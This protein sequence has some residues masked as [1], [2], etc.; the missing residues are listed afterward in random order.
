[1]I[2]KRHLYWIIVILFF[3]NCARQT[4]P[5]GGPKD[6]IPPKLIGA[7]PQHRALNF[8]GKTVELTFSEFVALNNPKEQL[9]ITP[10]PGKEYELA[11]KKTKIT[12]ELEKPLLDSTTYTFNFRDAVQDITE[13]NS[14]RNLLIAISTGSYL[15]SL[16]IE[17]KV[18]DLLKGTEL[19]DITVAIN[20]QNDTFNIFKHPATYFTKTN[21]KGTFKL[22]YLR[23]D[24]YSIYAID[25]RNRN[26][27]ADSR[28]E[29]YGFIS[30]PII[31]K[32]DT[33]KIQIA[34]I[35]L[36]ARPLKLTSARP[37][38]TY[39]NIKASKN[40]QGFTLKATDTTKLSYAY[41]EDQSTIRLF[42]TFQKI[43][44]VAIALHAF[45]SIGNTLDTVVYAKFPE[46]E[47][48]KEKF[49]ASISETR[50]LAE[51][52]QLECTF[53][54][55]KPIRTVNFD[56]LY[57][58]RDSL[59]TINFTNDDLTWNDLRTIA[60]LNKT[61]DKSWFQTNEID[62]TMAARPNKAANQQDQPATD[63]TIALKILNELQARPA[64]FV[65]VEHDSAKAMTE[66][67]TPRKVEDL[68]MFLYE[69]KTSEKNI[70]VQ[71]LDKQLKL[72]QEKYNLPKGQFGNVEPGEYSLRVILDINGNK[73]WDP[74]NYLLKTEPEK[75]YYI[76]TEDNKTVV[77]LK[78]NWEFDF[79]P[80]LITP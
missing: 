7:D 63:T 51:N 79:P 58:K 55:N 74:G 26:L 60:K 44:S 64:A 15:D 43:D 45:D 21:E 32:S 24:L 67:I 61:L 35:R 12:L 65:S 11:A 52:A 31:L 38:N 70:V 2:L 33:S 8:K 6:T 69:V 73:K 23:P 22:D 75:I 71:L 34:I 25:D 77:N 50:L 78:A 28:T 36:D 48:E 54:F 59:T 80:L 53:T 57:F 10:S 30:T 76:K 68:S 1:M 4:S 3:A 66:K 42:N 47:V 40:L 19:K 56:S 5:T 14:A 17:G 37:Y 39:F 9:I 41:G 49:Q 16:S 46:R 27:V 18:I 62:P 29:S 13:K 72:I 20:K